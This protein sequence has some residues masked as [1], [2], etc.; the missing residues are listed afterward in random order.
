MFLTADE[1]HE[2]TGLKRWSAQIRWL[3]D[4]H[5]AHAVR[6]DG[7]PIVSRK[8]AERQLET[9]GARR[10]SVG[11]NEPDFAAGRRAG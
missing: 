9:A 8:E 11:T 7:R 6:A 5:W 2:L 3:S 1:L 4:R 10:A